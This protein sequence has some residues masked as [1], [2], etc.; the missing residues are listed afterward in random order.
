M[1]G[2][3]NLGARRLGIFPDS[4]INYPAGG[5]PTGSSAAGGALLATRPRC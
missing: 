5:L 1:S 2:N 4:R 3:A